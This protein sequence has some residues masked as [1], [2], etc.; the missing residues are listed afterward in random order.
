MDIALEA[1]TF[2]AMGRGVGGGPWAWGPPCFQKCATS[3]SRANPL[4][5]IRLFDRPVVADGSI[6]YCAGPA[7]VH[8]LSNYFRALKASSPSLFICP[9]QTLYGWVYGSG[10]RA[11][12]QV[13][14]TVGKKTRGAHCS[15]ASKMPSSNVRPPLDHPGPTMPSVQ[16]CRGHPRHQ[17]HPDV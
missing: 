10:F 17:G 13:R 15:T 11:Y 8:T 1:R 3:Q 4:E 2:M 9:L 5:L 14:Q 12:L 16:G 7:E 6:Y